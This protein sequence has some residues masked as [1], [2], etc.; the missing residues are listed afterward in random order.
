[1]ST[2]RL[3][4]EINAVLDD[5]A[6]RGEVWRASWIAQEIC[7]EHASGLAGNDHAE[8]WRACGYSDCRREVTRCINARA[9]DARPAGDHTQLTLPGYEHLQSY[10]VVVRD[11]EEVGV[12]VHDL[13]DGEVESKAAQYRSMGRACFA[14]AKEL[15]RFRE[16]RKVA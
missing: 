11:D 1:M 2:N 6:G 10:Y 13:T 3:A 16:Q 15:E 14:H 4:D 5:L 8:F 7:A 12:S 9:G